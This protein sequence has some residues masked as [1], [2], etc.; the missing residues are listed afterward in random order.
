M[1]N[2]RS[3]EFPNANIAEHLKFQF[4]RAPIGARFFVKYARR[5]R[6]AVDK[7]A[8]KSEWVSP[9]KDFLSRFAV[10]A[11]SVAIVWVA[12]A[13]PV[14]SRQSASE[15]K[16]KLFGESYH[17]HRLRDRV[18]LGSDI[19]QRLENSRHRKRI[20]EADCQQLKLDRPVEEWN[21]DELRQVFHPPSGVLFK[22]E[23]RGLEAIARRLGDVDLKP[24]NSNSGRGLD[25]ILELAAAVEN[26]RRSPIPKLDFFTT[27]FQ[28]FDF[29]D[30]SIGGGDHEASN[31]GIA[32]NQLDSD[33]PD[34]MFWTGS[35][36]I[37]DQ[38]LYLGFGREKVPNWSNHVWQY[39]GAKTSSGSNPGFEV[40][41]GKWK[42]K[43]KLAETTSEPFTSRIFF[44][45]GY[46]SDAC[47][48]VE[49]LRVRYSRR[50][51][52]EFNLR[53]PV[54]LKISLIGPPLISCNLQQEFDPFGFIE[55]AIMRDGSTLSSDELKARLLCD[56]DLP[57]PATNPGN[58]N[59]EFEKEIDC[60][61][62]RPVNFQ[63]KDDKEMSVGRW[64]YGELGHQD[65]R[66]LR[67]AGLLAAWLGFFDCRFDNTSLR[68]CRSAEGDDR[69][70]ACF[71]DLGAGMGRSDWG[72]GWKSEDPNAFPWEFTKPAIHRGP[73]E[74]TTPFRVVRFHT[75]EDNAAFQE[76]TEADARWMAR[77]IGRL[78][79]DQIR[80][81]LIAA[82]WDA[83]ATELYLAKLISRRNRLMKD[84]NL[85]TEFP[86][87]RSDVSGRQF[88]YD[89]STDGLPQVTVN[90]Q[91][92]R[93][94]AGD[95]VIRNGHLE[96]RFSSAEVANEL[97]HAHADR[98]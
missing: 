7:Y 12:A 19:H 1:P 30:N 31:V 18:R 85:E 32:A 53:E 35:R 51:L 56:S 78:S 67:G 38:D 44:A 24:A 4:E 5:G 57:A 64:D 3:W 86:L 79:V 74:M 17:L 95:D 69:L 66:E 15:D 55:S 41:C 71:S 88:D 43:L 58:Y 27:G 42:A 20:W 48:H 73:G 70:V 49:G 47:D 29:L 14:V 60:L 9:L 87:L 65:L 25:E 96:P 39:A 81:A 33:P 90:G 36:S 22:K 75:I 89:P 34:S 46:N 52:R 80:A 77:R 11:L 97:R 98:R 16:V 63:L 59:R 68:V 93:A 50:L 13:R 28:V 92:V 40:R 84:L 26:V 21:D 76:M 2:S 10:C 94:S 91:P 82:G 6:P 62:L 54:D 83:S 8:R 72:F 23:R 37:K 61:V 45:L